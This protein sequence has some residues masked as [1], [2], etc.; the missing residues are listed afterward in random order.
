MTGRVL[1]LGGTGEARR[2]ATALADEGADVVSS[3]AGRVADPMLP[4]GEV[5]V[6]GFGGVA[7]LVAWLQ[8]HPVAAVVD[9]T[10]PFAATM[11]ASAAEATGPAGVPPRRVERR[12]GTPQ[13]V[14]DWR[15]VDS[16]PAAAE[17]VAVFRHVF[18][19]TGRMG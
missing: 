7:G 15:G 2:L 3:L 6:G 4:P 18:L 19:T 1:I 5:R 8:E 16:L 17:A 10:H 12:G 13:P 9:A 11:T 14:D